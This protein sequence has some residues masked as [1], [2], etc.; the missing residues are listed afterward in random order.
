MHNAKF[1]DTPISID[2]LFENAHGLLLG[3]GLAHLDHFGQI[4]PL[5]EFSHDAGM[6]LE[7]DDFVETDDVLDVA[8]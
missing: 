7:G 6:R 3:D 2:D 1:I 5:T 8:E 4:A